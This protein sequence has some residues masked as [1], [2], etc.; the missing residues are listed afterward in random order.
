MSALPAHCSACRLPFAESGTSRRLA[1]L[2]GRRAICSDC[3]WRVDHPEADLREGA[4][5][6]GAF[7]WA[8]FQPA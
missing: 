7:E 6:T 8:G 5:P 3:L 2:E 1:V 4:G